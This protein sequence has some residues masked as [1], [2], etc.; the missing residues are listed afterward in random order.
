[1]IRERRRGLTPGREVLMRHMQA[2]K[3]T[4]AHGAQVRASGKPLSEYL[5]TLDGLALFDIALP[6]AG[7][8]VANGRIL[9][10][11]RGNHCLMVRIDRLM[12]A[13]RMRYSTAT[14]LDE[15][16][17]LDRLMA[18]ELYT[19]FSDVPSEWKMDAFAPGAGTCTFLQLWTT[20][21]WNAS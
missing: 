15:M 12:V 1:V 17:P 3:G 19:R 11:S 9:Y 4:F 2:G 20:L 8:R 10:G 18:V 7:I 16:V 13:A 21:T 6:T 5:G 14:N